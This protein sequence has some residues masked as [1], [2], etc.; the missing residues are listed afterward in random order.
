[1]SSRAMLLAIIGFGLLSS[2]SLAG[3]LP[4]ELVAIFEQIGLELD[5]N[6]N[7]VSPQPPAAPAPPVEPITPEELFAQLGIPLPEAPLEPTVPPVQQ[8]PV[9]PPAA[10]TPEELSE[11]LGLPIEIFLPREA[12]TETL[13]EPIFPAPDTSI[14]PQNPPPSVVGRL[15]RTTRSAKRR[16]PWRRCNELSNQ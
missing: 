5:E 9:D 2:H 14:S 15:G 3:S 12:E 7:P 4:P 1:M 6:G 11:L 13:S 10:P 8:P 16:V